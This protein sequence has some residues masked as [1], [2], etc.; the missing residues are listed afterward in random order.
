MSHNLSQVMTPHDYLQN[1][2]H[3]T[4]FISVIVAS[5]TTK[6]RTFAF[7]DCNNEDYWVHLSDW[8]FHYQALELVAEEVD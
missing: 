3:E 5:E 4:Q 2:M 6:N 7:C 8:S 1:I